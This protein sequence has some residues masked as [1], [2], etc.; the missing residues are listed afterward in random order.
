MDNV[1]ADIE[2]VKNIADGKPV[3]DNDSAITVLARVI[4]GM[5]EGKIAHP[6]TAT[7][8]QVVA[9]SEGVEG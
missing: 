5:L 6:V 8:F 3:F 2:F 1:T 7:S 9:P 4:M